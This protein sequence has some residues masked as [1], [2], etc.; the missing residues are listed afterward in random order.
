MTGPAGTP[1]TRG[2]KRVIIGC[3]WV[4]ALAACDRRADVGELPVGAPCAS[5]TECGPGLGCVRDVCVAAPAETKD[6]NNSSIKDAGTAGPDASIGPAGEVS[7]LNL[8]AR[9]VSRYS[10]FAGPR[11]PNTGSPTL[12][13]CGDYEVSF[14]LGNATGQWVDRLARLELSI[15]GVRAVQ[16]PTCRGSPWYLSPGATSEIITVRFWYSA[17]QATAGTDDQAA[18]AYPCEYP[19]MPE[20]WTHGGLP[21][22]PRSGDV[23]LGISV[24]LENAERK[25][26]TATVALRDDT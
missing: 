20:A 3:G 18:I 13:E 19:R 24:L 1:Q 9:L 5:S 21:P 23:Q 2:M 25:D 4:F 14:S 6:G 11:D 12:I 8:S 15:G 26:S 16:N 17:A 10:C 22:V 7:V